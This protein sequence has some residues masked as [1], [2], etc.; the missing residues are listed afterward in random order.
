MNTC[1]VHIEHSGFAYA[2]G[3]N[4]GVIYRLKDAKYDDPTQDVGEVTVLFS[5]VNNGGRNLPTLN[6]VFGV[7][8]D[9]VYVPN[10][11]TI[12]A[13]F[14][15]VCRTVDLNSNHWRLYNVLTGKPDL[16]AYCDSLVIEWKRK[17]GSDRIVKLATYL[18]VMTRY[19]AAARKTPPPIIPAFF[20]C[21][22]INL[23]RSVL[24]QVLPQ[25][26]P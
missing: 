25:V 4:C 8:N 20:S 9:A 12:S 16:R 7:I 10:A 26:H 5:A 1:C 6:G 21:P 19:L 24:P 15:S 13:L 18:I 2:G 22:L 11:G 3:G 23:L 17:L 14:E